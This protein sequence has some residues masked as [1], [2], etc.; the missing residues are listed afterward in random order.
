MRYLLSIILSILEKK[1]ITFLSSSSYILAIIVFIQFFY[2]LFFYSRILFYKTEFTKQKLAIPSVSVIIC[3]HNEKVNLE[4]LIPAILK[5]RYLN[6]ELV[7]MDDRSE[8]GSYD[9]FTKLY[10]DDSRFRM[11]RIDSIEEGKN[12]KK[13][14]LTKAIEASNNNFLLLTDADCTPSSENWISS[15]TAQL[16]ELKQIVIG[17][18]PY[19]SKGGFLNKLIQYETVYTAI[20]YFSFAL[21]GV[22]YMAV[23]RNV[24]YKK[25]LFIDN[26]GFSSHEHITGGDDDLFIREVA[27]KENVACSLVKESFVYSKPKEKFS[28][29]FIQKRRHLSVGTHYKLNHKLLLGIQLLAHLGFYL[30]LTVVFWKNMELGLLFFMIRSLGFML[31]FVLIARKLDSNYKWVRLLLFIDVVFIFTYMIITTS[32]VLYKK[33]KWN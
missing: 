9:Y 15:M 6:F 31:I 30:L 4:S 23:G 11:L 27:T 7:V 8:D 29:W 13:Y 5:Q 26:K 19:E 33:I 10:K 28:E 20:Q 25:S 22:P 24:L 32:I 14:A 17:Y 21:A 2:Y 12:P 18:S 16:T 3:A 1:R